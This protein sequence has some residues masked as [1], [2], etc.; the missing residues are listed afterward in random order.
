MV[1][2]CG[3]A[4]WKGDRHT[5]W[6]GAAVLVGWLLSAVS[7]GGAS[8][9]FPIHLVIFV[10]VALIALL[11]YVSYVNPR[12]WPIVATVLQALGLVAHVSYLFEINLTPL[13][14]FWALALSAYGVLLALL[15]GT[16]GAWRERRAIDGARE[17]A[18]T[19]AR[20]D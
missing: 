1:S 7:Q 19:L 2:I 8:T 20:A 18:P 5:R 3:L 11:G 17:V 13:F 14:Y 4:M 12:V 6:V 16:V 9:D 10:D 15:V